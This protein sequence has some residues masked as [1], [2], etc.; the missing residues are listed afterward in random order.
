MMHLLVAVIEDPEDVES[1]LDRFY[2]S[3]ITGATVLDGKG[4]G[5]MIA[6]RYS[7]FARFADLTGSVE[8]DV[9]NTVLFTVLGDDALLE[10]AIQIVQDVVG[11]LSAPN[12]G[13]VFT[14]GLDRVIGLAQP[15]REN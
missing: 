1:I 8:E 9:H 10:R 3:D 4:M 7:I 6:H 14:V 11:D 5:H 13:L 2:E 15:V 12:T